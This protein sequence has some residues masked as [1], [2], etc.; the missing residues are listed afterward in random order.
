MPDGYSEWV[1]AFWELHTCRSF[2]MGA[3]P[4]PSTAI[5]TMAELMGISGYDEFCAFR[6]AIR[7]MDR[8]YLD[9]VAQEAKKKPHERKQKPQ[10]ASRPMT[11][12]LFSALFGGGK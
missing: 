8:V 1:S 9:H 7:A 10:V 5:L 4:I 2:A 11:P 12:E 3:G 6:F